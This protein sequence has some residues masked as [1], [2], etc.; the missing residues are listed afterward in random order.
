[1]RVKIAPQ[2]E[3]H[4]LLEG[5]VQDKAQRIEKVLKEESCRREENQ[6]QQF[7]RMILADDDVDD[8][9]RHCGKNNHHQRADNRATERAR[10]QP[11]V[12]LQITKNAPDSFHFL[13]NVITSLRCAPL[14]VEGPRL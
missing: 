6:R 1:M 7:L 14:N 3:N 10:R 2:I 13:L 5:V 4:F 12:T 8:P 11:R 9:F